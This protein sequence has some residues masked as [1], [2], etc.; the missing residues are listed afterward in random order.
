MNP[1]E[2]IGDRARQEKHAAELESGLHPDARLLRD[3]FRGDK[4]AWA[5]FNQEPIDP[6]YWQ[7]WVQH[8][9]RLFREDMDINQSRPVFVELHRRSFT[10]LMLRTACEHVISRCRKWP[11]VADFLEGVK[12]SNE[13]V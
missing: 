13:Q 9:N 5:R 1:A 10:N 12:D 7:M 6:D 8:F 2:R 3:V 4:K 11:F